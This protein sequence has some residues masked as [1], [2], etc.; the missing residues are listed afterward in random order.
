MMARMTTARV[1]R[2]RSSSRCWTSGIFGSSIGEKTLSWRF[3]K[4][5][6]KALSAIIPAPLP[7]P[8]PHGPLHSEEQWAPRRNGWGCSS[9]V[10]YDKQGVALA[11]H[12]QDRVLVLLDLGRRRLVVLQA[13]DGLAVDL[14]DHIPAL[15]TGLLRRAPGLHVRDHHAGRLRPDV[16][17]R[18]GFFINRLDPQIAQ[19]IQRP[20]AHF[21]RFRRR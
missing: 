9:R 18:P 14:L 6:L 10:D 7:H 1:S 4:K 3:L 20:L 12:Q 17:L 15:Q 16:E 11:A 19:D 13:G 5:R 8:P 21:P 2:T